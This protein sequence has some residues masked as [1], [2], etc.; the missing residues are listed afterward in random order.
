[1]SDERRFRFHI[2]AYSPTDIPMA[3]L[4]EYMADFAELLGREH[5]VHFDR[6]EDGS[7]TIVSR[8]EREDVPKV[9][10]RLQ[11]VRQGTAAKELVSLIAQI[12]ER[13][14]NDN[15]T[16]RI[17]AEIDGQ[18]AELIV[19]PGRDRP[20]VPSYGPFKQEGHLD[21][22]LISVGDKGD[23]INIRLQNGATIYS[24]CETTRPIARE[25]GRHMFEPVRIHGTGRWQRDAQGDW[26]LLGF[27]VTRF[28]VLE[29]GTLREAVTAL[30]AVPGSDWRASAI[31]WPSSPSCAASSTSCT[32]W[33]C[34]MPRCCCS[35][36]TRTRR[37]R[38]RTRASGSST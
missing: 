9:D 30:R 31:R 19:F 25:L 4:A 35:S 2:D 27:R 8:V 1:M 23:T 37:P 24:K 28:E 20:K 34:S 17:L 26:V 22:E 32:R 10:H 29:G 38:C 15:A 3:K 18:R 5:R 14:A 13:L 12:D 7:T 36:S 11:A 33:S 21:G 6:L 16:G